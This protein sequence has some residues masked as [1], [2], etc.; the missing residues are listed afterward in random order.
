MCLNDSHQNQSV[1]NLE[2]HPDQPTQSVQN[3]VDRISRIY[4]PPKSNHFKRNHPE[5]F[6]ATAYPMRE[7]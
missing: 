5:Y 2:V 3:I 6:L 1:F 4:A 7:K